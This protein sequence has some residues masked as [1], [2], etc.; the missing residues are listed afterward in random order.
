MPNSK[1]LKD[2]EVT[3]ADL[4]G[5]RTVQ[6]KAVSAEE[7]QLNVVRHHTGMVP[8]SGWI[9]TEIIAPVKK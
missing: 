2:F 7:A 1:D 8:K 4:Y 6:T 9:K 3:Y 5:Y